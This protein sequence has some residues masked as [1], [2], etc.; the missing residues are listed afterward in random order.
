MLGG[1]WEQRVVAR[2]STTHLSSFPLRLVL[3]PTSRLECAPGSRIIRR[4]T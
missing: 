3:G 4:I 2:R 1:Q